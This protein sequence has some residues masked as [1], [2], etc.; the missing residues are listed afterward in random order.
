MPARDRS[1]L[2]A[3][4]AAFVATLRRDHDFAIG[5][6]E[7][8][9]ALRAIE[10]VGVADAGR[11]RSALRLIC[12]A[13]PE[14]IGVFERVF[15]AFFFA[16]QRGIRNSSYAPRHT[17]ERNGAPPPERGARGD[18]RE[19]SNERETGSAV[20]LERM[21]LELA[22]ETV[23]AWQ[24]MRA[25][26]SPLAR[27]A[28]PPAIAVEGFDA[29][30]VAAS[31][32]IAGVRIGRSRRWKPHPHGARFDLRRTL[33]ASLRTGG[34][35]AILHR[36]G[37]PRRN[38]RFVVLIDGSRSMAEHA[39]PMLQFA[40]A[41]CRRTRRADAFSFSTELRDITRAL[42]ASRPGDTIDDL[43]EAWGGGTRIGASLRDFVR[44]RGSRL[45]GDDTVVIVFSDGLDVGEA[46][47]LERAMREI[48]RRSAAVVWLN[49]H[50]AQPGYEP[51]A[52][53]MRVALPYVSLLAT[54]EGPRAF[55]ALTKPIARATRS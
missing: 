39:A 49:P 26:Y 28:E 12:C 34:D 43:G 20:A 38:P 30:L 55:D 44:S 1:E 19:P 24:A 41:L 3:S 13:S 22:D 40:A 53:G 31:R 25:T 18:E 54:A 42:R 47:T 32:L 10:A 17:R 5:H 35:P 46:A 7:A 4:I 16:P 36:L 50:L 27:P 33:R 15:D 6:G 14:E 29:M 45:L 23:D 48:D 21:P 2:T 37:H 52:S 8:H 9:D 51:T 11:V